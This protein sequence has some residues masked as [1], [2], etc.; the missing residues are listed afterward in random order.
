MFLSVYLLSITQLGELL[1]VPLMV[2]HFVEHKEKNSKLTI[3]G[4]L[5]LHYQGQDVF[6]DD[7]EKDMKLP[8]KSHTNICCIA[9]YPLLQEFKT[10]QKVN[11][12]Y[13]KE[14]LYSYSFLYSSTFLSSIWQPPRNC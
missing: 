10:I 6:D 2:E 9:F 1:K 8:F 7:Y 5:R 4:F 13:K 14:N 3:L 12:K 11:Y